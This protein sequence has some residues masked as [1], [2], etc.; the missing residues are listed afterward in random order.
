MI[1]VSTLSRI[2]LNPLRAG[3]QR[4]LANPQRLHAAVLG[5][6]PSPDPE[7]RVL[8]RLDRD[9]PHRPAL[10]VLG[11]GMPDWSHVVEQA[12]WPASDAPQVRTADYASVLE[13]VRL[14]R[15]FRFRV[16]VNPVQNVPNISS[17]GALL[18]RGTRVG[19][20]TLAHQLEW[21]RSRVLNWGFDLALD[22][23]DDGESEGAEPLLTVTDRQRLSFIK[24][25]PKHRVVIQTAT[26]EGVLK[27]VDAELLRRA[28]RNGLGP[29]K[30]YGCGLLTL[31]PVVG[32]GETDVV[33]R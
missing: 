26:F 12:G 4:L 5:G 16:R 24:G 19:H 3:G 29:G 20:R 7:S 30:A 17:D 28:L 11:D 6:F 2:W 23:D 31:A 10:L 33:A 13:R 15:D 9:D 8:W 25:S 1:D 18:R 32:A 27:V 14:G 21:F 22:S